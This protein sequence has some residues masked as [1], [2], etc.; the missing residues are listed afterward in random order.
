V[1]DPVVRQLVCINDMKLL[2][3]LYLEVGRIILSR[4]YGR[5]TM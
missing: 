5:I 2:G 4:N 1:T 3:L